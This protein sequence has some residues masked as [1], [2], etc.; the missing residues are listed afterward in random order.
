MKKR[1]NEL[2]RRGF[3]LLLCLCMVAGYVP[4]PTFAEVD[5]HHP[6]HT[7]D[8]GYAEAVPASPCTHEHGD[9]CYT[10]STN[11]THVH[12]PECSSD[13]ESG[14]IDACAHICSEATGCV[15]NV[16]NCTHV[17]DAACGYNPGAEA[18]PCTFVCTE[19]HGAAVT[20]APTE[21]PTEAPAEASTE[22]PTE[23][24]TAAPTEATTEE[25]TEAPTQ[26][27]TEEATEAPT[28]TP[29]EP[30][31][32]TPTE[33]P[34]EEPT[35]PE[36][37]LVLAWSWVDAL[38]ALTPDT[39]VLALAADPAYPISFQDVLTCLPT[40]VLA[41]TEAEELTLPVAAW[42]CDEY[43]AQGAY[44][45]TY[46]FVADLP[47][48]YV[49]APNVPAL[50][51]PVLFVQPVTLEQKYEA[52][53][54]NI[55]YTTLEEAISAAS[56]NASIELLMDITSDAE[57][58]LTVNKQISLELNGFTIGQNV[59]IEINSGA[60]LVLDNGTVDATIVVNQGATLTVG[61]GSAL[62]LSVVKLASGGKLW[63][64]S[65]TIE[66]LCLTGSGSDYNL[67]LADGVAK[68]TIGKISAENGELTVGDL[69]KNHSGRYLRYGNGSV[70]PNSMK[71]SDIGA[72]CTNFWV[73][74]CPHDDREAP[75]GQCDVCEKALEARVNDDLYYESLTTALDAASSGSTVTLLKGCDLNT[76]LGYFSLRGNKSIT[77]NL[78]SHTLSGDIQLYATDLT[79]NGMQTGS[80][81]NGSI[82]CNSSE[83]SLT[84]NGGTYKNT[85]G[86]AF[87]K[88]YNAKALNITAG[89]FFGGGEYALY[90]DTKQIV[91]S[92]IFVRRNITGGMFHGIYDTNSDKTLCRQDGYC[93]NVG[94]QKLKLSEVAANA[95]QVLTIKQCT[96]HDYENGKSCIYCGLEK[97]VEYVAQVGDTKYETLSEALAAATSEGATVTL[98]KNVTID[99]N[100]G[101]Y[102]QPSNTTLTI[103]LNGHVLDGAINVKSGASLTMTGSAEGSK[104]T[105]DIYCNGATLTITSGYYEKI[106]GNGAKMLNISGGEVK[107]LIP[108]NDTDHTTGAYIRQNITGGTFHAIYSKTI[109]KYCLAEGYCFWENGNPVDLSSVTDK[110]G[111]T[112]TYTTAYTVAP[113]TK[114]SFESDPTQEK[115]VYCDTLNSENPAAGK[116]AMVGDIYY[117]TFEAAVEAASASNGT[118]KIIKDCAIN[119]S[120][121][122]NSTIT[123]DLNGKELF[124]P[125]PLTVNDG[126]VTITDS[127]ANGT[128]KIRADHS[129]AVTLT[130]GSLT[131]DG[132]V[133]LQG[134]GDTEISRGL[135]VNSGSATLNQGAV[136]VYG[137]KAADGKTLLDYLAPNSAYAE[138]GDPSR[139]VDGSVDSYTGNLTVVA[140]ENHTIGDNDKCDCG[141][142]C[143]HQYASGLNAVGLDNGKCAICGKQVYVA[144]VVSD[145]GAFGFDN[146]S[147]TLSFYFDSG[148]TNPT[149]VRLYQDITLKDDDTLVIDS[150]KPL[151]LDLNGHTM[152]ADTAISVS[153]QSSL[154]L[155]GGAVTG[156]ATEVSGTLIVDGCNTDVVNL[157][158]SANFQM[159]TGSVSGLNVA[160]TATVNISGGKVGSADDD[161][162][163]ALVVNGGSVR[164]T[165]GVFH[166][167]NASATGGLSALLAPGYAFFTDEGGTETIFADT[168]ANGPVFTTEQT[169]RL[170][171]H[172]PGSDGVC[173]CGRSFVA[174]LTAADSAIT[175]YSSLGEA[176]EAANTKGGTVT[177]L[178]DYTMGEAEFNN[179][180]RITRDMTLDLG[181]RKLLP[182]PRT[183]LT[184]SSGNVTVRNGWLWGET[185]GKKAIF[186]NGGV[187]T[188]GSDVK[189]YGPAISVQGGT[190]TLNVS[191]TVTGGLSAGAKQL[192]AFLPNGAA[193]AIA[194]S[195]PAQLLD[196]S[197][198]YT[199][200]SLVV[201]AHLAHD[202]SDG[203]GKCPCGYACNHGGVDT[204]GVYTGVDPETGV[205]GVCKK[206]VYICK[207]TASDETKTFYEDVQEAL[208]A[209]GNSA[210][211]TLLL[212][213]DSAVD[214]SYTVPINNNN[215]TFDLG[216]HELKAQSL[217]TEGGSTLTLKNGALC[218]T[219]VDGIAL[220]LTGMARVQLEK[221]NVTGV[222]KAGTW[223]N[224]IVKSGSF[225]G[226]AGGDYALDLESGDSAVVKLNG[227]TFH[228]I[229]MET[230]SLMTLL[231]EGKAFAKTDNS[232]FDASVQE[233]TETLTVVNH[234]HSFDATG[235]CAC[236]VANVASL[237]VGHQVTNYTTLQA[238][239]DAAW[240]QSNAT[241]RLL[242]D[243]DLGSGWVR[244]AGSEIASQTSN[245]FT[246]NLNGHT[247]TSTN[248]TGTL[249]VCSKA[250]VTLTD[251]VGSGKVHNTENG[252]AIR[253]LNTATLN[254]Q[255]GTYYPSVQVDQANGA[256]LTISGGV[257]QSSSGNSALV[258]SNAMPGSTATLRDL[259]PKGVTLAYKNDEL[260]DVYEVAAFDNVSSTAVAATT[261]GETVYVIPHTHSVDT[262]TGEC[263]CGYAPVATVTAGES[264]TYFDTLQEAVTNA[265]ETSGS[266]LALMK[267]VTLAKDAQI[268]IENGN[269]TI[270]WNGHTLTG[271]TWKDLLTVT[272]T[273]NITLKDSKGNTGGVR[274]NG[275]PGGAAVG[276]Y[277]DSNGR[278]T[279]TGG[280]YS[281]MVKKASTAAG[282]MQISGGVFR[283]PADSGV[284][285]A[286]Y[287]EKGTLSEMLAPGHAFAYEEDGS[288]LINSYAV[289]N[290]DS[291]RAVY[292]VD[293]TEHTLGE[294][295]YCECECG[296]TCDHE[297]FLDENGLCSKCGHTFVAKLVKGSA[298]DTSTWYFEEGN[299]NGA[300]SE[301]LE[302]VGY[303]QRTLTL[304]SDAVYSGDDEWSQDLDLY[305][306]GHSLNLE[307]DVAVMAQLTLHGDEN[308]V[309][310]GDALTIVGEGTLNIPADFSGTL[311]VVVIDENGTLS[312]ASGSDVEISFLG[313]HAGT[314]SLAGGTYGEITDYTDSN[315]TLGDLL[316]PGYIFWSTE[317]KFK[318]SN[319]T[320]FSDGINNVEVV[321]CDH[322]KADG[323]LAYTNG[324]CD[325]CGSECDHQNVDAGTGKC[326]DCGMQFVASVTA[327]G[328]ETLYADFNDA[329][330]AA[331][332]ADGDATVTLLT[333]ASTDYTPIN[334]GTDALTLDLGSHTLTLNGTVSVWSQG[335]DKSSCMEIEIANLAL[336]GDE[337]ARIAGELYLSTDS[338]LT[339][340][341][342]FKGTLEKAEIAGGCTLTAA[343]TFSGTI[344]TLAVRD[345]TSR[346]ISLSGGH[347][348]EVTCTSGTCTLGF[349]LA[350]G[351]AFKDEFNNFCLYTAE[352]GGT[353]GSS[354]QNLAV[355]EC[356]RHD[357]EGNAGVCN[358]CGHL[359]D[360]KAGIDLTNFTCSECGMAYVASLD[361]ATAT[362]QFTHYFLSLKEAFDAASK[363]TGVSAA[364]IKILNDAT[365]PEICDFTGPVPLTLDLNGKYLNSADGTITVKSYGNDV[366]MILTDST[367]DEYSICRVPIEVE[368]VKG[369]GTYTIE[370]HGGGWSSIDMRGTLRMDGGRVGTLTTERSGDE[371]LVEI[372]N[373]RVTGCLKVGGSGKITLTGGSFG[374]IES[375]SGYDLTKLLLEDYAFKNDI[376]SGWKRY[377]DLQRNDTGKIVSVS[378]VKCEQHAPGAGYV[379]GVCQYCNHKCLH[380]DVDTSDF[381][382]KECGL[383]MEASVTQGSETRYF[384][385]LC[386]A[387]KDA[388][389][390]ENAYA[391]EATLKLLKDAVCNDVQTFDKNVTLD[392]N[393]HTITGNGS[394]DVGTSATLTLTD[395]VSSETSQNQCA[396]PISASG[397]VDGI[398]KIVVTGGNWIKLEVG[399][400]AVLTMTGGNVATLEFYNAEAEDSTISGGVVG[401]LNV[402][403]TTLK[404]SGGRFN[405]IDC[406]NGQG[407]SV[408][409]ADLL[410]QWYA[411]AQED[412][413]GEWQRL[414]HK[415]LPTLGTGGELTKVAV[416][417]CGT[418]AYPHVYKDGVCKYCNYECEHKTIDETTGK[419]ETCQI[420]FKASVTQGTET[421][422]YP[423]LHSALEAVNAKQGEET[424]TVKLLDGCTLTNQVVC[425][426]AFTLDQNGKG[427]FVKDAVYGG[428]TLDAEADVILTDTSTGN[429]SEAA[430]YVNAAGKVQIDGGLWNRVRASTGPLEMTN[431]KVKN[432]D[433]NGG[434]AT[435]FGGS[436]D[437]LTIKPGAIATLRGGYIKDVWSTNA[438]SPVSLLATGYAFAK[439]ENGTDRQ[440]YASLNT[441]STGTKLYCYVVKCDPHD[442]DG[443]TGYCKYCNHECKDHQFD[444]NGVCKI[445]GYAMSVA[446]IQGSTTSFFQT[447]EEAVNAVNAAT[448]QDGFTIQLRKDVTVSTPMTLTKSSTLD[449][450]GKNISASS[451]D[452]KLCLRSVNLTL[453]DSAQQ[454]SARAGLTIYGHDG[455]DP[456]AASSPVRIESGYWRAVSGSQIEMIDGHVEFLSPANWGTNYRASISGGRVDKLYVY[457]TNISLSGGYIGEVIDCSEGEIW[458]SK[459]LA[460]RRAFASGSDGTDRRKYQDLPVLTSVDDTGAI[461]AW[462]VLCKPHGWSDHT[463][464][465]IYCHDE[466]EHTSVGADGKC[467]I[468]GLLIP[469]CLISADGK[470]ITYYTALADA[471]DAAQLEENTGCTVR[472]L[473]DGGTVNGKYELRTGC[474]T[475][476]LNGKTIQAGEKWNKDGFNVTATILITENASVTFTGSGMVRPYVELDDLNSGNG[477]NFQGGTFSC[478]MH[479]PEDNVNAVTLAQENHFVFKVIDGDNSGWS[480]PGVWSDGYLW[481]KGNG[482]AM[483]APA[484]LTEEPEDATIAANATKLPANLAK[485]TAFIAEGWTVKANWSVWINGSGWV[486][487]TGDV[488]LTSGQPFGTDSFTNPGLV[489]GT[490]YDVQCVVTATKEGKPDFKFWTD[491]DLFKLTVTKND[492]TV[493]ITPSENLTY[494]GQPQA[495]IASGTTSEGTTLYYSLSKDGYYSTNIP[496]ATNAGTYEVWYKVQGGGDYNDTEPTMLKVTIAQAT[497]ETPTLS[498]KV[499]NG[500]VQTA[501]VPASTLYT[502][503][504]NV[505]GIAAGTYEVELALTDSANYQ[506]DTKGGKTTFQITKSGNEWTVAPSITGW[507][508]GSTASQ[509]TGK[510]KF[511]TVNVTYSAD[512]K[513]FTSDVPA[514]AG[515]YTARFTVEG[516]GDYD[517]LTTD[518]TFTIDRKGITV[519]ITPNGG[520]YGGTITPATAQLNGVVYGDTVPM[521]L[522]YNGSTT[523]P[524]NAGTYTIAVTIDSSNY[525][526]TGET[527]AD[528]VIAKATVETPTLASKPYTGENQTAD[529]PESD[530]YTVTKNNGGTAVGAYDVEL[531]LTDSD[532]YQWKGGNGLDK[533]VTI[534]FS[535]THVENG[536]NTE[537]SIEGWI[538]GDEP[539]EPKYAAK[540]GN[541]KVEYSADGVNYTADVPKNVGSYKV[542]L[543]VDAT[544]D[545]A[546]L[547][548]VL[549]VAIAQREV[550]ITNTA[551]DTSKVYDGTTAANVSASGIL[552]NMVEGDD[553]RIVLGT[554]AYGDK[555]VGTAK[556]V[557]FTGFTLEGSAAGNYILTGQP[558]DT[559]ADITPKDITLTVT[560]KEKPFDGTADAELASAALDGLVPGDDVKL[561]G[562]KPTLAGV[563]PG[564]QNVTFEDFILEGADAGNY[565]LTN[566]QP[567]GVTATVTANSGYLDLTGESDFDS[568]TD[569]SIDGDRY[570]IR[571][572]GEKRYV[573]LPASCSLLTVYTYV[574]GDA[575]PSHTN[576]PTSMRVYRI[577]R[578]DTGATVE[579]IPEL[580]D[581]LIYNGCS[582]RVTGKQGIRM[583]TGITKS[584]KAALTGSGLAGYT[585]VEY[586]T[587]VCWADGLP[588]GETLTLGKS[589]ARSNFAYRRGV[590][591]PVF[592]QNGSVMQYT[593][594]L[595]GFGLDQCSRDLIMRPYITLRDAGGATVTLYGGSVQ[596]S[597]GY[598]ATQNRTV[599][600][601]G[602]PAYEY[603]WNIIHAVY[604]DAY[605]SDYQG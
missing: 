170:H 176:I 349:F 317:G 534:S 203:T 599:F 214:T 605:D 18:R 260:V 546:A 62:K 296:L 8:C 416:V 182:A 408:K 247:L 524:T 44:E 114:H 338:T 350:E 477:T 283:N 304:L 585:L 502:V 579:H 76:T 53:V 151:I 387:H 111:D 193:F 556:T 250:N 318:Y 225:D 340:D 104:V 462:V 552:E 137:I 224:L 590:A 48:G 177:L 467:E 352:V 78:N 560:V 60:K 270:D 503:A 441:P 415:N 329:L 152:T 40:A 523:V 213:A 74:E 429:Q 276:F 144:A 354:V 287:T 279:I 273:A 41:Y 334:A 444:E 374:M 440:S 149:A 330:K 307:G 134:S 218:S 269:F 475:L 496:Q 369:N 453:K 125:N 191:V 43:P 205:C 9:L 264:D 470:N 401:H 346:R 300:V 463:G 367:S 383:A 335:L 234:T 195:N 566:P 309:V 14:V 119:T 303:T 341:E 246:L 72:E 86:D 21:T 265:Q 460:A 324:V 327:G 345:D 36:D 482:T 153:A 87:L 531:T 468:C 336:I 237:T 192:L 147:G 331:V 446:V 532:N 489:M 347:Y 500:A 576:Y 139:L 169:V 295:G 226:G 372:S 426:R 526:L 81:M 199:D 164:L 128:G 480:Q 403:T 382:C 594:V 31:A 50:T 266:T 131:V 101:V 464:F 578:E 378:V 138:Q 431:G 165:G 506:W 201:V 271:E 359:C 604:G 381:V 262:T 454:S 395:S 254:I 10:Y 587:V 472:L 315:L 455:V 30:P 244:M 59:R 362:N 412:S 17:H 565:H 476:D 418:E 85:L 548:K 499:Y 1:F 12:G 321:E 150:Q 161:A 533:S 563:T 210:D 148:T 24:P 602:T 434:T 567:E 212:L 196:A 539:N 422:Y 302:G 393:G 461:N 332:S 208:T 37:T 449:L 253:V 180:A 187:L 209:A 512:G 411:F 529:V 235:V 388:G 299:F 197:V 77:V 596:R 357:Y 240:K 2:L 305:L 34:T 229:K 84:I 28:E 116:V 443:G 280:T 423:T 474:F 135:W 326:P 513:T 452:V 190:L 586:G 438:I 291:Y 456:N 42:H 168:N 337:N 541:V 583:I 110:L 540:F 242:R 115:C 568:R 129:N 433:V 184:V 399:N 133:T 233:T 219:G 132:G 46:T 120:G 275:K 391:G 70:L 297:G 298:E 268:Y 97:Q 136:I 66:E 38:Q 518:K 353:G 33:E 68:S 222:V 380:T 162:D 342:A 569:V 536:W 384:W 469:V 511:G 220:N 364:T 473:T 458:I 375:A 343:S 90:M 486:T 55:S 95:K 457:H 294:N 591:D 515:T 243:I 83:G 117:E 272:Q 497:V 285:F 263:P 236:G 417:Q 198:D 484:Y 259:L 313:V 574:S 538:Y 223:S 32:E 58:V 465:C 141:F 112:E 584:N 158:E 80:T 245:H 485:L 348:G 432:L 155:R 230:A 103:D 39:G 351:Y 504:K 323:T 528:F 82:L 217:K 159:A 577:L 146:F 185:T 204:N 57:R 320:T 54:G 143:Q 121:N 537:P 3:A 544:D 471:F 553:V 358:Y 194:G 559:Q 99:N 448:A 451:A 442:Y 202:F 414:E 510:A 562:G 290:T 508:Y 154:T 64:I 390:A 520:T 171:E 490:K 396:L 386:D 543:T 183:P 27:T 157:T 127:S 6:V 478:V 421:K 558:A 450:N 61:A 118:V 231:P 494:T 277:C 274:N 11:C 288:D 385:H 371:T 389:S 69:L 292:V 322:R 519:T 530:L 425:T 535:I 356:T 71:L 108:D 312:V 45:G 47:Q 479:D 238:A 419:C 428:Y 593:N 400:C 130:G 186:V 142:T 167:I 509:P 241:V 106:N 188:L 107:Y 360:H 163:Y 542:R 124:A 588:A 557:A 582:I 555:N 424:V 377:A 73:G 123:I 600:P 413:Q 63:C 249:V 4:V 174:K 430:C 239:V 314:V 216:G 437:D 49:L 189:L 311:G 175:Y 373:G 29:T 501:D 507:I 459:L 392:L 564:T 547:E 592:A 257:F 52:K 580:D 571:E 549:D 505:G 308:S 278:L 310:D 355:V 261:P 5:P 88:V 100:N 410:A 589:C 361:Y 601:A 397:S 26:A 25:A 200:Q 402:R 447:F 93:F 284:N 289:S 481:L 22:T 105:G 13:P 522:T 301:A 113:C 598:I 248:I 572:E 251:F 493:T 344:G 487:I 252:S 406:T 551:V 514:N 445:C 221:V 258:C 573:T 20:E 491:A 436:V 178:V 363:L 554:A 394:Y 379:D 483:Q 282:K 75:I 102:T 545:F 325:Y 498:S 495:L 517:G 570:P 94:V 145:T 79:I 376:G 281:P 597:I 160:G 56:N 15:T 404:L 156:K 96:E 368:Y 603:V 316:V 595:V 492:P 407:Y 561:T 581:L 435:I 339:L 126:S 365:V 89:E 575:T 35:E 7:A 420:Q 215:F 228:G 181:G 466:C 267:D 122:V 306:N 207:R 232:L 211:S 516:T 140:H 16:L 51:V 227:G 293:H 409:T 206:Q 23:A 370:V 333:D 439:G 286:L 427:I 398:S 65:G 19:D 525:V 319:S 550:T 92:G 255:G 405:T 173:G 179:E 98:L 67:T 109:V 488:N 172:D 256:T 366:T 166:G 91:S 527:T 521:K 328:T